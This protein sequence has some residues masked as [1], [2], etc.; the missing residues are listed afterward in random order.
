VNISVRQFGVLDGPTRV[1][2]GLM[3]PAGV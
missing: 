1:T 3:E 2:R